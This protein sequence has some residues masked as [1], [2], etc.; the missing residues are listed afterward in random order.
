MM[1]LMQKIFDMPTYFVAEY[2]SDQMRKETSFLNEGTHAT[3]S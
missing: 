2:V 3:P 1:Y